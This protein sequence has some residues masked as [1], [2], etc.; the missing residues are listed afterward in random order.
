MTVAG[1]AAGGARSG[2]TL[3]ATGIGLGAVTDATDASVG[4]TAEDPK[5]TSGKGRQGSLSSSSYLLLVPLLKS[6]I[7]GPASEG[8]KI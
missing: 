2:E 1:G 5:G 4:G 3:A 8:F 6:G 7:D